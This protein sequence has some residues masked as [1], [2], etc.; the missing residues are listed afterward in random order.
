MQK[1]LAQKLKNLSVLFVEDEVGIREN[2][3]HSL[4]YLVGEVI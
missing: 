1:E 3:V 2:I 4:R